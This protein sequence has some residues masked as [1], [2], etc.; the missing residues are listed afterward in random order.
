MTYA[1]TQDVPLSRA[2]YDELRRELGD[3]RPE[4]MILH[5]VT[6]RE[7]G[8]QY[9]D[10]W[11]SEAACDRFVNERVNPALGRLLARAGFTGERREPPRTPISVVDVWK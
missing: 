3:E 5:L 7:R 2:M 9:L 11:E 10:V 4:G 6:E 8:L 1:F